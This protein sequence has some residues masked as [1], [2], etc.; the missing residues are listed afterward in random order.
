[1]LVAPRYTSTEKKQ[2]SCAQWYI[3]SECTSTSSTLIPPSMT[4]LTYWLISDRLDSMTPLGRD[5]VPDVY[6]S[7][8]G[9]SSPTSTPGSPGSTMWPNSSRSSQVS[10]SSQPSTGGDPP[11]IQPR[12]PPLTPAVASASS[13]VAASSSSTTIPDAPAWVRMNAIS[14][15][16]SIKL[17]GTSTTP[18]RAVANATVANCQQLCD[19]SASRSPFTRPRSAS[20]CAHRL[21]AA[22]NSANV[23]RCAPSTIASLS[24]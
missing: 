19:S 13:A 12:T 1:M 17:I 4:Q 7:R 6:I 21:T 22:S 5:S 16:V 8:S 20:A 3:G 9:S 23:S 15:A 14:G 10:K 24:G 11:P 18:S 2:S